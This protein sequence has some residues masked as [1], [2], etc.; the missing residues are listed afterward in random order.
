MNSRQL[1]SGAIDQSG[2]NAGFHELA[3]R[4]EVCAYY[5]A[6]MRRQLLPTGR[7]TYLP[8]TEYLGGGRLR[9][10]GGD[11]IAV[12]ARRTVVSHID[13]VVPSM[14]PPAYDVAAG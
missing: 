10:L 9:T 6:V 5:E 11:E 8:M 7:V 12:A 3:G 1:G 4:A 2:P 13:V 14:R